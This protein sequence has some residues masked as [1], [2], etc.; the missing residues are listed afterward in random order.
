VYL[1]DACARAKTPCYYT[2][3][4]SSPLS[5]EVTHH[6]QFNCYGKLIQFS[7]QFKFW[8]HGNKNIEFFLPCSIIFHYH[9]FNTHTHLTFSLIHIRHI[10]EHMFLSKIAYQFEF[11]LSPP[12]DTHLAEPRITNRGR[13]PFS[14]IV[15]LN[16]LSLIIFTKKTH[17]Y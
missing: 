2:D 9:S 7:F 12:L 6:I 10:Q 8:I 5:I 16:Y 13:C 17:A 15:S 14:S 11:G 3:P 4:T 1:P